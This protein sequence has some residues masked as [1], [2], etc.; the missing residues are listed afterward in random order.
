MSKEEKLKAEL[1]KLQKENAKKEEAIQKLQ[2][3]AG[4]AKSKFEGKKDQKTKPSNKKKSDSSK[5]KPAEGPSK[6][7]LEAQLQELLDKAEEISKSLAAIAEEAETE[8]EAEETEE[9]EAEDEA[10]ETEEAEDES[11]TVPVECR[12]KDGPLK[13]YKYWH[14]ETKSWILTTDLWVANQSSPN[15]WEVI[16]IWITDGQIDHIMTPEEMQEYLP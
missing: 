4:K 16:W 11:I 14:Y 1:A 13:A 8:D 5:S 7:E 10:E 6:E 12:L 3:E 15:Q 2:E 9:A